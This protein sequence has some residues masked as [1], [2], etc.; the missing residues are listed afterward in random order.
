MH[1][2]TFAADFTLDRTLGRRL[3]AGLVVSIALH[4][5][6]LASMRP[7]PGSPGGSER[8]RITARVQPAGA[9]LARIEP[10]TPP[11]ATPPPEPRPEPVP[12]SAPAPRPAPGLEPAHAPTASAI[13]TPPA[14]GAAVPPAQSAGNA[15]KYYFRSSEVDESARPAADVEPAFEKGTEFIEGFIVAE[16]FVNERG[17][18][19]DV[20][21]L[22]ADPPD[23]F[24][25]AI[26]AALKATRF[27]PAVKNGIAVKTAAVYYTKIEP[28]VPGLSVPILG[29]P[30]V[31]TVPR[32]LTLPGVP[33]LPP[34]SLE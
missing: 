23:V 34:R 18:V 11:R 4:G 14:A 25:A 26:V 19:D 30:L 5:A 20:V 13:Q 28:V 2:T 27:T 15:G 1:A 17:S 7:T 8:V 21:L 29:D 33:V 22:I 12:R 9:P 10:P 32:L 6:L 3:A 24:D 16:V 31:P